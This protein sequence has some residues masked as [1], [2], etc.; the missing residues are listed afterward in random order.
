MECLL[1]RWRRV[2]LQ[3][4]IFAFLVKKFS[5]FYTTRIHYYVHNNQPLDRILSQWIQSTPSHPSSLRSILILSSHMR[6]GIAR[7][8]YISG[9]PIQILWAVLISDACYMPCPLILNFITVTDILEEKNWPRSNQGECDG[10]GMWHAWE[11]YIYF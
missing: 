10:L 2:S 6:L 8:L 9:F 3:K 7:D 4:L 11:I 5:A 1:N